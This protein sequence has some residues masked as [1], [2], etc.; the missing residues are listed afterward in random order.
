MVEIGILA[1]WAETESEES[2]KTDTKRRFQTWFGVFSPRGYVVMVFATDREAE[3]A[4]QLLVTNGFAQEDV[5]HYDKGEV[6]AELE[7]SEEQSASPVQIGQEVAKVD[8]YLPLAKQGCGFL[9]LHAPEDED[10]KR[11]V[12][13]VKPLG[14]KLAEKYNRL[15]MEE[16]W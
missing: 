6:M 4:R 12:A 1:R 5:T 11:A 13:I 3:Q 16:L 8:T 10:A 9:V 15:T 7:K 14:L 2:M